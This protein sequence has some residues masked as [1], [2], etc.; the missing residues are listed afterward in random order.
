MIRR[1][2]RSRLKS[3]F[4]FYRLGVKKETGN[5]IAGFKGFKVDK[6][7]ADGWIEIRD[8]GNWELWGLVKRIEALGYGALYLGF[9]VDRRPLA[10][11]RPYRKRIN[12]ENVRKC[13]SD[14][15]KHFPFLRLHWTLRGGSKTG[16][17][18]N[19]RTEIIDLFRFVRFLSPLPSDVSQIVPKTGVPKFLAFVLSWQSGNVLKVRKVPPKFW[20]FVLSLKSGNVLTWVGGNVLRVRKVPIVGSRERGKY[21][22][23]GGYI[24]SS[25]SFG[26]GIIKVD[27]RSCK[28][29][30]VVV[31][32]SGFAGK[33][34]QCCVKKEDGN[35]DRQGQLAEW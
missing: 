29:S 19:F 9:G 18:L 34:L 16:G 8:A 32:F 25:F 1:I 27:V 21:E 13:V 11:F 15:H 31:R 35:N 30:M 28:A 24:P 22:V 4:V 6:R 10:Y 20:V 17:L 23:L 14:I 12:L 33:V 26:S 5:Y 2:L 3:G 7:E